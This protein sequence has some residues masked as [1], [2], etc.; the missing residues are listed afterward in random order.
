VGYGIVAPEYDWN[1]YAGMDVRGKTVVMLVNDPGFASR[2]PALFNGTAMT[3]YGRWTYKYEEAARQGAAGALIVHETA[4]AGYPWDVVTGSWAGPQFDLGAA[5]R[6]LHRTVI[7]GWLSREA[8]GEVFKRAGLDLDALARAAAQPGFRARPM[9][10][11]I[12][13]GVTNSISRSES[14]NVVGRIE[15]ATHPEETIAYMAHW[16]HLGMDQALDGDQIFNGA[17]DNAS[18]LAGLLE[19]ARVFGR[20]ARPERSLVFLALTAEESGLL[21]SQ[22]Y[23]EQ[24]LYPLATTVAAFN[25]DGLNV[26]GPT[27]DVVVVGHGSSELEEYLAAA[28]AEQGRVI[29]A[30]PTPEKGFFYRSDHFNFASQ[31]VPVLYAK[32]GVDHATGGVTYGRRKAWEYAALR[33]HKVSD[34]FD[35]EWDLRGAVEDLTLLYRVGLQLA[36]SRAFP[37]WYPG[38]EFRALRDSS[39]ALRR[40]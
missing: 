29:V 37:N 22:Y 40:P 34:E 28:V 12:S 2:D 27:H 36:N 30:E 6:N 7:E 26:D 10:M 3:Y 15:G 11:S 13:V 9:D 32:S 5:D 17:V 31:G 24:P 16:D 19:L 39:A 33:Y 1:D 23:A 25:M 8:A 21:G 18:G 20:T 14:R 38:N 4:A 35:P